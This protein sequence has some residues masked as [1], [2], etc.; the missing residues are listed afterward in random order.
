MV[1]LLINRDMNWGS[2][3]ILHNETYSYHE[4]KVKLR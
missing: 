4:G 2:K 3:G 1:S